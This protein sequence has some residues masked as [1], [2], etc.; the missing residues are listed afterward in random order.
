MLWTVRSAGN[1][2][3]HLLLLASDG[4][5]TTRP[6]TNEASSMLLGAGSGSQ[7]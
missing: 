1:I 3:Q 6:P 2:D 4:L 5:D 7:L